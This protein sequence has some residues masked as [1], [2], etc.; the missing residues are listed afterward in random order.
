MT[1]GQRIRYQAYMENRESI[2]SRWGR[3]GDR[4]NEL[5]IIGQDLDK[6]IIMAELELCLCTNKEIIQ[7][8]KGEKF[9]DP[10]PVL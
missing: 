5:V 3:F 2:E 4:S 7:M 10:F 6:E 9:Q 1:L 8:E